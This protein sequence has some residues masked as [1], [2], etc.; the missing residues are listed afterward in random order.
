MIRVGREVWVLF[1]CAAAL[2][3]ILS[4]SLAG[5]TTFNWNSSS[6][7]FDAAANWTQSG[8][9]ADHDGV[10]DSSDTVIFDRGNVTL[11]PVFFGN[12]NVPNS[13]I[14]PI[15]DRVLIGTNP[16][17][18]VGVFGSTLTVDSTNITETG[19]G[20]VIGTGA[21]DVATLNSTLVNFDTQY[22]TLGSAAGSSGSLNLT[23]SSAGTFSVSGTGAT[24]DLIV[25]LNGTGA[26]NITNGR[27]VTVADDT[28]LG[29]NVGS[30]GNV[31]VNGVGS[32][33][34]NTDELTIGNLGNGT[35]N[36]SAGGSVRN[37]NSYLGGLSSSS[38]A[39]T[40]SGAGSTWTNLGF[41][42]I[43]EQ[44]MGTLTIASGGEVTSTHS[45]IGQLGT[46]IAHVSGVGTSWT[47]SSFLEIGNNATGSLTI[48]DGGRVSNL[49]G[50]I[51]RTSIA[52]GTVVVR[53]TSTNWTN[54]NKLTVGILGGGSLEIADNATVSAASATVNSTGEVNVSTSGDFSIGNLLIDGGLLTADTNATV[55]F[56]EG[57]FQNGATVT[58]QNGASVVQTGDLDLVSDVSM[59]VLSG[60]SLTSNF[61]RIGIQAGLAAELLVDGAGTQIVS[62]FAID[63]GYGGTG[64]MTITGG[65]KLESPNGA[66]SS[67]DPDSNGTVTIDGTDASGIPSLWVC[68]N[69]PNLG[70][71]VTGHGTIHI[72]NGGRLESTQGMDIGDPGSATIVVQG[73]SVFGNPSLLDTAFMSIAKS[74]VTASG[75]GR[76]ESGSIVLSPMSGNATLTITDPGSA[77]VQNVG[78][79]ITLGNATSGSAILNVSNGAN[80]VS[81]TG[82]INLNATGQINLESGAVFDARGPINMNGGQFN[83]LG[84]TLH[85]DT[86]NGNLL[87]QGGTLAPGHST[88]TTSISGNYTQ[89]PAAALEIEIEGVFPGDWDSL[90]VEGNAIL[91]G[92]INVL[93]LDAFEPVL[94][95]SFTILTTNVGNVAGQFETEQFPV[96]NGLTFKL[97]YNSK[98]VVL[99]VVESSLPGDFD[100]DG[101]VDG[102]DFL[103]WQR[104]PSIGNLT[105]WQ[106]NYG[107]VPLAAAATAVPEPNAGAII[108]WLV[109]SVCWRGREKRSAMF[110]MTRLTH[111]G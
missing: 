53:G 22:A 65:A 57:T 15:V 64:L 30:V 77:L 86:F 46:G 72:L 1:K 91:D 32:T 43:G 66:V 93:L 83:F 20:V 41:I 73:T 87:N 37:G 78:Y 19:R 8:F 74:N 29:L 35:L 90:T 110:N 81:G 17:T 99:Q 13:G 108:V 109:A 60:A 9:P 97:I 59:Q 18:F 24:Y 39:V 52:D 42:G 27:D 80:V 101:D 38:G 5:G 85:F 94:G 4:T 3:L 82:G 12:L 88:G 104:N 69:G 89:R 68:G 54:S 95:N 28:V 111:P 31:S 92:T 55:S 14:H 44:G 2:G 49:D 71:H 11:Y 75:G 26:M 10:P 61:A 50:I 47:N 45:T 25:G 6:G 33:W 107:A 106:T 51:G 96:F 56:T 100:L 102:R 98:N 23:S 16:L 40:I 70:Y 58:L 103:V 21:G 36:I 48:E 67:F 79:T 76:I 84:G 7:Q 105:D 62:T 34:I 63:V